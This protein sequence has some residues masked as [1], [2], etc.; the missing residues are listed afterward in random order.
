MGEWVEVGMRMGKKQ[1]ESGERWISED[2]WISEVICM[3]WRRQEPG[4]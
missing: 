3:S 2:R 4:V 1:G